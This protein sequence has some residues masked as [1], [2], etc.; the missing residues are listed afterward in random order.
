MHIGTLQMTIL[1]EG[2]NVY[3]NA[4]MSE[5]IRAFQDPLLLFQLICSREKTTSPSIHASMAR[6]GSIL[7]VCR[8]CL[9]IPLLTSHATR[10]FGLAARRFDCWQDQ[11]LGQAI[12]NEAKRLSVGPRRRRNEDSTYDESRVV[13][14]SAV[15]VMKPLLA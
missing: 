6:T 10:S 4:R 2:N 5:A 14:D 3:D 13:R 15:L 12:S 8:V 7:V 9:G 11:G 1:W